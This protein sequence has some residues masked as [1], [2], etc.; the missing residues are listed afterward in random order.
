MPFHAYPFVVIRPGD[1]A[2]PYLPAKISNPDANK[3]IN[4]YALIDTGADECALPASFASI[5]G[6]RL[7]AGK[8]KKISTGNG[9]TIAFGHSSVIEIPGFSTGPVNIDYMPQLSTPLLGYQ[10]FLSRFILKI[11]YQ[12]KIFS[13]EYPD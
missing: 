5:L 4:V 8:E 2:R 11:N 13:L 7:E 10:S 3:S 6:H 9:I 12:E 1:I